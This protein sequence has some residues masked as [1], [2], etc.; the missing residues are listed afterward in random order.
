LSEVERKPSLKGVS[1]CA[2]K[3]PSSPTE[4]SDLSAG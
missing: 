4:R 2:Q 3:A 1:I